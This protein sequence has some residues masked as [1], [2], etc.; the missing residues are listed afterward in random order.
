[1]AFASANRAQLYCIAETSWGVTPDNGTTDRLTPIR[2][3]GESLGFNLRHESSREVRD[4]RQ[5]TNLIRTGAEAGGEIRVE[6]SHGAH[7]ALIAGALWS[8]WSA[9]LAIT[10]ETDI[11][12][13]ATGNKL[14]SVTAGRFATV[15]VGQWL[16]VGGFA[17]AANNGFFQVAAKNG[18]ATE[19]TLTGG[20]LVNEAAGPAVTLK[21]CVLRNGVLARSFTIEKKFADIGQFI[22]F[23]G[24]RVDRCGLQIAAQEVIAGSFTFQG[25]AAAI[26]AASAVTTTPL[27]AV[28]GQVVSAVGNVSAIRQ[29]GQ[30]SPLFFRSLG[31]DIANN[32]RALNAVGTLGSV[33]IGVGACDVTGRLS[34]YFEDDALY[35]DYLDGVETSL[36]LRIE[37][38]QGNAYVVTLPRLKFESGQVLAEGPN[39]DV[40]AE[41]G[42]RALRDPALGCT[43]Q[44]DRFA[45]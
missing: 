24:M 4:D 42:W 20:T 10:G 1:M 37:D 44:I 17:Q 29:G 30:P 39:Q 41:L 45:A 14:A 7:D 12:A 5:V 11:A 18:A 8:D 3:T 31:I 13:Q 22:A 28:A 2:F 33:G 25:K 19:L 15:A 43:I 40:M 32:L 34:A 27:D 6:L 21:G 16:R 35:R 36:S 9:P 23:T 26:A 38:G